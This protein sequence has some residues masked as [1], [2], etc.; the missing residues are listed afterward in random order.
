LTV[1][2]AIYFVVV[3]P[4]NKARRASRQGCWA[5]DRCPERKGRTAHRDPRLPAGSQL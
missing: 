5:R 2:A 1:G 4:L 3:M